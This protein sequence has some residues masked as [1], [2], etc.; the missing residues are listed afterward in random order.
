MNVVLKEWRKDQK[1]LTREILERIDIA[2]FSFAV[3]GRNKGCTL[4]SLNGSFGYVKLQD[5]LDENWKIY[6]FTTDKLL[7]AYG[8]IDN[9][10]EN[11]V[12]TESFPEY[13]PLVIDFFYTAASDFWTDYNYYPGKSQKMLQNE[14][15][16][17]TA[18][19][20]N[21]KTM[22]TYC[23]RGE[24]FSDGHW[25]AMIK[26]GYIKQLFERLIQIQFENPEINYGPDNED[27]FE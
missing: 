21:I 5:A 18:S 4:D 9:L 20:Q 7:G 19:L 1:A 27:L 15:F 25:G 22:L 2:A 3:S 17:K 8:S 26:K 11:G 13:D 12:Y 16:I 10:I 23:V 14:D 24:R 6:D